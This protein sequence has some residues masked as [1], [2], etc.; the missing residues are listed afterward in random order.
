MTQPEDLIVGKSVEE[1]EAE[2]GNRVNSPVSGEDRRD[3][4]G[5]VLI[6]A[7]SGQLGVGQTGAGALGGLPGII[8]TELADDGSGTA[9]AGKGHRGDTDRDLDS[10]EE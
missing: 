8:G 10:S 4:T 2:T 9:G 1:I 6:P 7:A 3:G 5:T